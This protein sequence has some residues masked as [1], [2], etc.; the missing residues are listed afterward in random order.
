MTG[1]LHF[2]GVLLVLFLTV[3]ACAFGDSLGSGSIRWSKANGLWGKRS[4]Y[5]MDGLDNSDRLA[6]N[7]MSFEDRFR[8]TDSGHNDWV[9]RT[10]WQI[11]NGLWGRRR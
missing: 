11:A 8:P 5:N 4:V 10:Q 2:R 9:K 7:V 3:F 1:C 6:N